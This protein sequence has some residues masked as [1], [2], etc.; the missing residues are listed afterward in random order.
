MN[1]WLREQLAVLDDPTRTGPIVVLDPDRLV[2]PSVCASIEENHELWTVDDWGSLR[3]AWDLGIRSVLND[4]DHAVVLV[5]SADFPADQDLPWDIEHEA[6]AVLRVRWPVPL[7]LRGLFSVAPQLAD[8]LAAASQSTADVAAIVAG[9][10]RLRAGDP[11]SELE[12]VAQLRSDPATPA[13]LWDALAST[14]RTN[15]ARSVAAAR[16]DLAPLQRAWDNWLSAGARSAYAAE[17]AAAPAPLI[18]LLASGMLC[19]AVS[20]AADLP[21]WTVVGS[22]APE[23]KALLDVLLAQR[24]PT[25]SSL[26][27]WIETA[28][29]WGQVRDLAT[30]I[31][32]PSVERDVWSVWADIDA[33]FSAW[34]SQSYGSSLSSS[35]ATPRAVHQVA[36]FL[37]R[38]VDAG[39][40]VLLAVV[41]GLSFSNWARVR[42]VTGL[43]VLEST[44]C[45][46]MIPTLTT[47]SRQ[48]ILAGA[49]PFEFADT[50]GTTNAEARRWSAFWTERGVPSR[51]VNY[52]KLVGATPQECPILAGT[53]VAVVVNAVD[54][55]MHGSEVLGDRQVASSVAL[56]ARTGFLRRLVEDATEAGFEVWLTADHGNLPTTPRTVP[57]EGQFV[58]SAGT[59]VRLYPNK[60][61]RSQA[62]E[63][64]T[65]WDPPGMPAEVLH[66]LFAPGRTGY[67]STGVRVSHGGLSLDEVMV[68]FVQV[69][70]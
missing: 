62:Q 7:E 5:Q 39:A 50:I 25:P 54:E 26:S 9:A 43:H 13:E 46:A 64:G 24:P 30:D 41:D 68:P 3:R 16:G 40:R 70:P 29:W 6:A 22:S 36:P 21:A 53:A 28:I 63:Q 65:I 27:G 47:V 12:T 1:S 32:D 69:C 49:L 19:P 8:A 55:I 51:D 66:P 10:L 48:A 17:L 14:L 38:R 23:P 59:R 35:A 4:A 20:R 34:L 58:E 15:V 67:H 11:A 31:L 44:G 52:I 2:G 33:S 61:L 37:A 56:W 18:G 57:R 45:L 42:S 60:V